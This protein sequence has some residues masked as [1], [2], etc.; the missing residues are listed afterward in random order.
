[1]MRR[2]LVL[3]VIFYVAT[4]CGRS[5]VPATI[6]LEGPAS[7][8]PA[9]PAFLR[10]TAN[11]KY[12]LVA[13]PSALPPDVQQALRCSLTQERL[14]MAATD[15]P[16]SLGCAME[17]D[18]P[19]HHLLGAA[20]SH[21]YAVVQ[22]EEGGF[23]VVSTLVVFGRGPTAAIPLWSQSGEPGIRDPQ[24][25]IRAL[26]NGSLWPRPYPVL[27]AELASNY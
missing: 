12:E 25:L 7:I 23:A 2:F 27:S 14:R 20:V 3:L 8:M 21:N 9:V 22:Y 26:R 19:R 11:E 18:L 15:E 1:L 24:A 5:R 16:A 6:S 10:S 13:A 4:G 17:G